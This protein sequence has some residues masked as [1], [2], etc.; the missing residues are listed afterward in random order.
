MKLSSLIPIFCNCFFDLHTF[1]VLLNAFLLVVGA[2][3]KNKVSPIP[4]LKAAIN[5]AN[6]RARAG[7]GCVVGVALAGVSM[8]VVKVLKAAL[9]GVNFKIERR[10]Y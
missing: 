1:I 5:S 9:L 7:K 10:G 8:Q 4:S 2:R 3:A 6:Q